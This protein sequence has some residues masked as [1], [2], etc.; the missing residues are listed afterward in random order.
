MTWWLSKK[1]CSLRPFGALTKCGELTRASY[2]KVVPHFCSPINETY[3]LPRNTDKG[4]NA[5]SETDQAG[6]FTLSVA[7]FFSILLAAFV[8]M[9][10]HH[11]NSRVAVGARVRALEIGARE[12]ASTRVPAPSRRVRAGVVHSTRREARGGVEQLRVEVLLGGRYRDA[13]PAHACCPA[14]MRLP[15]T[16]LVVFF[17]QRAAMRTA[18][19]QALLVSYRPLARRISSSQRF[20]QPASLDDALHSAGVSQGPRLPARL[21]AARDP[22]VA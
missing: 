21:A 22:A 9:S 1:C 19:K 4:P 18:G 2:S 8:S 7:T 16:R 15:A 17:G 6:P 11:V 14:S 10:A 12:L 3:C 20:A 5:S 13:E